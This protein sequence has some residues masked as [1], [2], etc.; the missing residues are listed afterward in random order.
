MTDYILLKAAE[1]YLERMQLDD[2]VRI[3]KALD[4]LVTDSTG[5]DIKPLKGRPELRLR[6]GKYRVVF[7][8]DRDN[9]VYVVTQIGSRGDVYK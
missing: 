9:Q 6:V 7:L 4:A 8:E 1:R 2:Q 3:V 5:L